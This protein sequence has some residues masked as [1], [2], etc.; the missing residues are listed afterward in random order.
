MTSSVPGSSPRF[1]LS[2]AVS[3]LLRQ[4]SGLN[5]TDE[6]E[7][8]DQMIRGCGGYA[9]EVRC[10]QAAP[11]SFNERTS[12]QRQVLRLD[13]CLLPLQLLTKL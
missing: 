10:G 12:C 1:T 6:V 13:G 11:G 3:E 8:V 5:L 7:L 4:H 9:G 2:E